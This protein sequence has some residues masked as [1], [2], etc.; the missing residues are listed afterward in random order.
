MT[1]LVERLQA[2]RDADQADAIAL[3]RHEIITLL[4]EIYHLRELI[5]EIDKIR[6]RSN[7]R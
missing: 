7:A 1:D 6:M 5:R 3:S 2:W 4:E